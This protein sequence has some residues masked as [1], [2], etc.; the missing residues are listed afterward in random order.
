M[1]DRACTGPG[2]STAAALAYRH[3]HDRRVRALY[4]MTMPALRNVQAQHLAGQG[5]VQVSWPGRVSKHELI[6]AILAVE[7]PA[8]LMNETSHV[9]YHKSGET[10]SACKHCDRGGAR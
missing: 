10:W 4:R 2:S 6:N 3:S 5:Y 8:D 1:A 9:L 7:F